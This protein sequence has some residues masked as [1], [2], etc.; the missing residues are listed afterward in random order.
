LRAGI[1]YYA[2]VWTDKKDN[3]ELGKTKL[4]MPM[5]AIGGESSSSQYVSMLFQP[6]AENVTALVIPEAGHW[7]GDENPVFLVE[8]LGIFFN[9]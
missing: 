2:A 7:L 5:L 3:E 8:Q 4:K 9:S 1:E 6:V